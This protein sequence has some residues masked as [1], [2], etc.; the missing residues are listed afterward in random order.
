[1]NDGR[2]LELNTGASPDDEAL[3][4]LLGEALDATDPAPASLRDGAIRALTWDTEFA[5]IAEASFDSELTPSGLRSD[6]V[7]R[8]LSFT[9]DDIEIHI[10]VEGDEGAATRIFGFVAPPHIGEVEVLQPGRDAVVVSTDDTGRFTAL[11]HSV[12][13]AIRLRAATGETIRTPLFTL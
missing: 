10:T 1:M 5:R 4:T 7:T 3:L 2:D 11:V 8:D 12:A 9:V 6:T 13:V